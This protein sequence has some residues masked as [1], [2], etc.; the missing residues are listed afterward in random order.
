M[1]TSEKDLSLWP[2]ARREARLVVTDRWAKEGEVWGR[3]DG[4]CCHWNQVATML[5]SVQMTQTGTEETG[6]GSGT[7]PPSLL[8]QAGVLT[9]QSHSL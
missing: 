6:R 5:S 1:G 2:V 4:E 7:P 8:P 9:I 3:C